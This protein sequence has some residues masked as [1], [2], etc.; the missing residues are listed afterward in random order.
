MH[1]KIQKDILKHKEIKLQITILVTEIHYIFNDIML[2]CAKCTKKIEEYYNEL[3]IKLYK[4]L[5]FILLIHEINV[6]CQKLCT[7]KMYF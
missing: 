2:I 5:N 7:S 1:I 4:L 3:E 6:C